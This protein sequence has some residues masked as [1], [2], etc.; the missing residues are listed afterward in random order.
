[1]EGSSLTAQSMLSSPYDKGAVFGGAGIAGSMSSGKWSDRCWE[2]VGY[3][4]SSAAMFWKPAVVTGQFGSTLPL[5]RRLLRPPPLQW[6][7]LC[8][9]L[10]SKRNSS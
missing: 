8:R 9:V 6:I 3:P 10:G 5:T 2:E 7:K 4:G 1:M